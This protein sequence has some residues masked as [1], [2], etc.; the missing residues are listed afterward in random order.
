[1]YRG[2]NNTSIYHYDENHLFYLSSE[3]SLKLA[4]CFLKTKNNS[5]PPIFV[6]CIASDAHINEVN[7]RN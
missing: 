7:I 6:I 1:M 3:E 4:S 2:K 5:F